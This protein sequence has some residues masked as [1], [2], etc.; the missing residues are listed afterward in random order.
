M[1][2]L[3]NECKE[4]EHIVDIT[5][6]GLSL[7]L[8][9]YNSPKVIHVVRMN[10]MWIASIRLTRVYEK[11][12]HVHPSAFPDVTVYPIISGINLEYVYEKNCVELL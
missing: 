6:Q 4:L 8:T 2:I 12:S 5:E 9:C 3:G 1:L 7:H 11:E 10:T